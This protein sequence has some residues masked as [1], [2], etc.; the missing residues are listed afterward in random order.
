MCGG[1]QHNMRRP[2]PAKD[3]ANAKLSYS[4]EHFF[5]VCISKL[6]V[7]GHGEQEHEGSVR[8]L[9][10]IDVFAVVILLPI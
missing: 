4:G 3:P 9:P 1:F 2:T 5:L 8:V 7:R 10:I 6:D